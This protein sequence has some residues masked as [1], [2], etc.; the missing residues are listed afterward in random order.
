MRKTTDGRRVFDRQFKLEAIKRVQKG[1]KEVAVARELKISTVLL[2]RWRRKFREGGEEALRSIGHHG[3]PETASEGSKDARIA[4]LERLIGRKQAA[5]DF[6]E[7]ALRRV[8]D[9][10]P[11]K[12]NGGAKGSSK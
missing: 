1:E 9:L 7:Q 10:R 5:I 3:S 2:S 4:E 11:P 12:K 6:L 8:E